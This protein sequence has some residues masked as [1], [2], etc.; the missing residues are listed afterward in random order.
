MLDDE[1]VPVHGTEVLEAGPASP[2]S[3]FIEL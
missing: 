2:S 3:A 1:P